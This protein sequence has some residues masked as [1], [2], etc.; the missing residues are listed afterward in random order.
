MLSKGVTSHVTSVV[1]KGD[2]MRKRLKH[3]ISGYSMPLFM[4]EILSNGFCKSFLAM[5]IT[6]DHDCYMFN[7]DTDRMSKIQINKLDICSKLLLIETLIILNSSAESWYI[8]GN[9]YLLE[10]EL[11]YSIDNSVY[12]DDVR[13]LF[14]PDFKR[15]DYSNKLAIFIE[16][17]KTGSNS[18]ECE[19]LDKL[20]S[21]AE[22][23]DYTRVIR[24]LDK[25]L[26]RLTA[27]IED[28]AM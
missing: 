5:S 22:L 25:Q 24:I 4:K 19:I 11:I 23:G 10:P 26:L 21:Y 3:S 13:I 28:K 17:L 9:N 1:D 16:K 6:I 8:K 7:Y 18:R 27:E 2:N 15:M 14:Y 20:K 12:E